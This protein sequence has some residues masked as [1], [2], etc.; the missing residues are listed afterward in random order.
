MVVMRDSLTEMMKA[1][2]ID[3]KPETFYSFIAKL[4]D[5]KRNSQS[6]KRLMALSKILGVI[7]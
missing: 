3:E 4:N 2:K 1:E 6:Y 5:L 7:I